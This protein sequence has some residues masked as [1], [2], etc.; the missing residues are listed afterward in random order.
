MPTDSRVDQKGPMKS[1]VKG[2]ER[3]L[4]KTPKERQSR[5]VLPRTVM[6]T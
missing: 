5:T 1:R 6:R 4:R 2:R 3:Q